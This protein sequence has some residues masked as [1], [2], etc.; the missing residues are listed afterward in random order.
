[1]RYILTQP[2]VTRADTYVRSEVSYTQYGQPSVEFGIARGQP[3]VDGTF[4][5]RA[6]IWYRYDGGWID[7]VDPTTAAVVNHNINYSNSIMARFGG[8]LAANQQPHH[9]SEL[10]LPE[11]G[12]ARRVD[13][14]DGV[15]QSG[16]GASSTRRRPSASA[17]R[18]ITTCQR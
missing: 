2:S 7:R 11:T 12:Q 3:L 9:H 14:L 10:A 17:G 16:Q 4:G 8:G 15:F 6:S 1:V 5:V 18:T 13:L